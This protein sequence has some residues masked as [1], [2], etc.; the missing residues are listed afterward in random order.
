MNNR[1][2]IHYPINDVI[3]WQNNGELVLVPVFQ[4]RDVWAK[5][6]KSSLIDTI[7][8][9]LPIPLIIIRQSTDPKTNKTIREVVD[10]QQ[11][12]RSILE[13]YNGGFPILKTHNRELANL[14]FGEL[15]PEL[16]NKFREY[17][18]AV[19]LLFGASDAEILDIFARLNSYTLVLN[20][21]EKLNAKYQGEFRTFVYRESAEYLDFFRNNRILSNARIIRM[22]EAEFFSELIIAMMDGLQQ[23]KSVIG[24]YFAK[25]DDDFPIE[26]ELADKFSAVITLIEEILGEGLKSTIFRKSNLFYSLFCAFYDLLYGMKGQERHRVT[27]PKSAYSQIVNKLTYLSDQAEKAVPDPEYVEFKLACTGHVDNIRERTVRHTYTKAAILEA[28]GKT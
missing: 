18:L 26:S 2:V 6:A 14:T 19:N 23:G 11:R 24:T 22:G 7:M 12:L 27:F 20:N 17:M 9:N 3:G 28:F 16:Q 5:K 13:F 15:A 4:R 21:Q 8:R 1:T 25:Y 10:G